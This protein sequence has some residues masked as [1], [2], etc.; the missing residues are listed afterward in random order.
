[1]I[2]GQWASTIAW[3]VAHPWAL[4]GVIPA[5][6]IARATWSAQS[7]RALVACALRSLALL[8]G[9]LAL[10]AP[11][12]PSPGRSELPLLELRDV[13][14]STRQQRGVLDALDLPDRPR[15]VLRFAASLSAGD[16]R[17]LPSPTRVGP[18]LRYASATPSSGVIL[19][20]DGRFADQWEPAARA[21]GATGAEV[22]IV[23]MTRPPTDARVTGLSALQAAD[24]TVDLLASVSANGFVERVLT[25]T[26]TDRRGVRTIAS[27]PVSL[28]G[29]E[30][31]TLSA[32]DAP[33]PSH[34]V[35]YE[36]RIKP[37]DAFVENDARRELLLPR[38]GRVA[39]I[40]APGEPL[41]SPEWPD[42]SRVAPGDAPWSVSG[43]ASYDAV[44]VVDPRGELLSGRQ[45]EALGAYVRAGG[46]LV[47]I[48]AGPHGQPADL[49]D[50][51]NAVL[52]LACTPWQRGPLDVAVLLDASGSMA[53]R[54][55]NSGRRKF[56]LAAQAVLS[57]RRHLTPRDRLA[58]ATFS[59]EA[60][61]IYDANDAPGDFAAVRD[62]LAQAAPRGPTRAAS[63]LR[64]AAK[65]PVGTG[66]EQFVVLVTDLLTEGFDVGALVEALGPERRLAIVAVAGQAERT[67]GLAD[68]AELARRME[69]PLVR[70]E[71]LESLA[72]V[73]ARFVRGARPSPVRPGP[74]TLGAGAGVFGLDDQQLAPL[75]AVLDCAVADEAE[76]LARTQR[77]ALPVIARRRVGLGRTVAIA[78][79]RADGGPANALPEAE[80]VS[81]AVA[82]VRRPE[83]DPRASL[84]STDEGG[85]GLVLTLTMGGE[86][87]PITDLSPVASLATG[88]PGAVARVSLEQ[89]APGVYRG[90]LWSLG[91]EPT[92]VEVRSADRFLGRW[93]V[94]GSY[95]HEYA[96][97]GPDLA[98]LRRLA[99]WTGGRVVPASELARSLHRR[100]RGGSVG[101]WPILLA[102]ALSAMLIEWVL[103]RR[104]R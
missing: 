80:L 23:P 20:T 14:G 97:I 103:G 45:R 35:T 94:G 2:L 56:D 18:A 81:R 61:T 88:E 100:S 26:A 22:W 10:S 96:R 69:A 82:W 58:V 42:L 38:S 9:V 85:Q 25:L 67:E 76:V 16:Q 11:S 49:D 8:A 5:L 6:A 87:G 72:D 86:S 62:A 29:G 75:P 30:A 12:V 47:W 59:D 92:A 54:S 73:F 4:V 13:S 39:L 57:L 43:W 24:G 46:G 99:G 48:G 7:P 68:L 90:K 36:A 91:P 77:Q 84:R 1:M 53:E 40:A 41:P 44:A 104:A 98:A 70:T 74:W 55:V 65:R 32:H 78:A 17:P 19:H 66:R 79:A 33:D 64:W 71:D 50:P 101:L 83:G 21:L 31:Y 27:S 37:P 15:R 60:R 52:P 3:T 95:R 93:V 34:A 28:A 63:A 89:S 102:V 51:I